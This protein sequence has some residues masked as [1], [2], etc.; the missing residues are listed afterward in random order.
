MV[1]TILLQNLIPTA[2]KTMFLSI[3]L[4]VYTHVLFM[5]INTLESAD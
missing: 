5:I 3:N 2:L 1:L 4:A